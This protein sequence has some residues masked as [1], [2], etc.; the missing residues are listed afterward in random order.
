LSLNR[1]IISLNSRWSWS[2]DKWNAIYFINSLFSS[3]SLRSNLSIIFNI[4]IVD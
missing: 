3:G 2:S 4:C 1:H